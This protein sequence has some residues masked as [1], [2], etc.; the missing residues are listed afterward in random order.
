MAEELVT[1]ISQHL[2][3]HR[4][5]G[6]AVQERE[7]ASRYHG[8]GDEEADPADP[9]DSRPRLLDVARHE[10]VVGAWALAAGK[11][12]FANNFKHEG[13]NSIEH[14]RYNPASKPEDKPASVGLHV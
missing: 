14:S 2:E 6:V 11:D 12:P 3:A 5:H 9:F 10:H 1:K 4:R 7:N 8:R 13:K